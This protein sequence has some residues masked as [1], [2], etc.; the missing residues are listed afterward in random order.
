[1]NSQ[2]YISLK[3]GKKAVFKE[4]LTMLKAIGTRNFQNKSVANPSFNNNN[5]NRNNS[6]SKYQ[7]K[8]SFFGMDVIPRFIANQ[9]MREMGQELTERLLKKKIILTR[10]KN[11]SY[12]SNYD[13]F[14]TNSIKQ[15]ENE[16][17]GEKASSEFSKSKDF[18]G[19]KQMVSI[20]NEYDPNHNSTIDSLQNISLEDYNSINNE[21]K[22]EILKA[23]SL[24]KPIFGE[25]LNLRC[26]DTHA[27]NPYLDKEAVKRV[28]RAKE[29]KKLL[30]QINQPQYQPRVIKNPGDDFSTVKP[31]PITS[32]QISLFKMFVG[33]SRIPD[34]HVVSYFDIFNPRVILAAENYFRNLYGAE[35]LTLNYYYPTR[36]QP[37]PRQHQFRFTSDIKELYMAAQDDFLS[38]D[39]PCLY[40]DN[41]KEIVFD[42]KI[43]CIGALNLSNNSNIKVL[44][45]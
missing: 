37:G 1:M 43:K 13:L 2:Q 9:N 8:K 7:K 5:N 41:G 17:N 3:M 33:N 31:P 39:K 6:N 36:P 28:N 27:E 23:I 35:K 22:T 11:S 32:E 45:K 29:T 21:T 16:I 15:I 19:F 42:K 26:Y 12:F 44:K 20:I 38:M 24:N 30:Q 40:L 25:Q 18:E 10:L 4:P 14:F 34:G